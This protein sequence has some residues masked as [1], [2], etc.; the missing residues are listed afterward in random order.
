VLLL[1]LLL[2]L[3]LPVLHPLILVVW[4]QRCCWCLSSAGR[5][6]LEGAE[7]QVRNETHLFV[8]LLLVEIDHF[9]KTGLGQPEGKI[10]LRKHVSALR[11]D[12][13]RGQRCHSTR[14]CAPT[15]D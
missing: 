2:L 11:A 7:Q 14:A 1:L 5:L 9:V 8:L 13:D 6:A 3:L 10:E 12:V 15:R 4:G